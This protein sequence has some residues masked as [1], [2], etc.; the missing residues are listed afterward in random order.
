[1]FLIQYF[2]LTFPLILLFINNLRKPVA[3]KS[4]NSSIDYPWQ[5]ISPPS[6]HGTSNITSGQSELD[7]SQHSA[8]TTSILPWLRLFYFDGV[9]IY[10]VNGAWQFTVVTCHAIFLESYLCFLSCIMKIYNVHW[11]CH[12]TV[13]TPDTQLFIYF[14]DHCLPPHYP[15]RSTGWYLYF[16]QGIFCNRWPSFRSLLRTIHFNHALSLGSG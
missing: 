15:S 4:G 8:C 11:T 6:S 7:K 1:M 14:L 9:Y 3:K 12:V 5:L 2:S 16:S 13:A 10:G